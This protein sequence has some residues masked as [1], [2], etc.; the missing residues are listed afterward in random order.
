MRGWAVVPPGTIWMAGLVSVVAWSVLEP[1]MTEK[2]VGIFLCRENP[3]AVRPRPSRGD[4]GIDVL[5]PQDVDDWQV[6]VFQV[7]Y[8]H[9]N[10]TRSQK[11]QI[12]ESYRRLRE[13]AA[14]TGL[15]VTAWYLTLPLNPTNE[16]LQWLAEFTANAEFPCEWRGL[17]FLEG[18][19]AKYS[20]VVDYYLGNGKVRLDQ[21]VA[22]LTDVL[23]LGQWLSDGSARSRPGLVGQ[24]LMP[25]ETVSGLASLHETLNKYDPH[26]RYDFSVDHDKP[27]FVSVPHLLAAVQESDGERWVTF[28]IFARFAEAVVER[29]VPGRLVVRGPVGSQLERDFELF[30]DYGRPF[31][32]PAGAASFSIDL[33]GG[34]GRVVDEG[35]LAVGPAAVTGDQHEVR[36]TIRDDVGVVLAEPRIRMEPA[37]RGMTG[38]GLRAFGTEEHGTFTFEMMTEVATGRTTYKIR[39][40]E[41]RGRRP[42]DMLEGLRFLAQ[43]R[44]PN[45]MSVR[46]G[47]GP[48]ETVCLNIS[49]TTT[50]ADEARLLLE[51]A[52]ALVTIQDLVSTRLDMPDFSLM[53]VDMFQAVLDA[54]Q[55]LRGETL[56]RPWEN[57]GPVHGPPGLEPDFEA[58]FAV[59]FTTPLI[60]SLPG[61][62]CQVGTQ[63]AECFAARI[64]PDSVTPHGDHVDVRFVPAEGDLARISC[65]PV[66]DGAQPEGSISETGELRVLDVDS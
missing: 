36:L 18:L 9:Q 39:L 16:N 47:Y 8:F 44:S 3:R 26:F 28:K 49:E 50:L 59:H 52:E 21:A 5:V 22:A 30:R 58:R 61:I 62:R 51:F 2:L 57:L 19:A 29:P 42:A 43:H 12:E 63:T 15:T 27:P 23:R 31:Q 32:T 17:D 11:R 53:D 6:A 41:L 40:G 14:D 54:A 35:Q 38:H 55:L 34:F 64:D 48:G 20:D 7:K 24:Q 1:G 66:A 46:P 33:P 10:L 4:G 45:Q 60:L 37:T 65:T 13:Y 56:T 25:A